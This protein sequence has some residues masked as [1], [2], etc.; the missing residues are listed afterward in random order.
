MRAL[1]L[2]LVAAALLALPAS[3]SADDTPFIDWSSW[4]P[5]AAGTYQPSSEDDCRSGKPRC[6]EKVIKAMTERFDAQA[7]SCDHDA[8]FALTYLRTT[9]EYQRAMSRRASSATR[10]SSTTRTRCSPATTSTPTTTGTRQQVRR[11]RRLARRAGRRRQKR[12][13]APATCCSASTPTSTATCP[14]CWPASAWSSPTAP[15][16]SPTTTRSTS[17]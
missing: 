9:E 17:S 1:L 12:S 5:P 8:M 4:L 3:A 13:A 7:A 14:T 2:A 15:A 6:V 10:T 16:A 11:A